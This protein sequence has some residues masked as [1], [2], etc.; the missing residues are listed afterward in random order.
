MT[1]RSGRFI[2]SGRVSTTDVILRSKWISFSEND[3][4]DD[5]QNT[6]GATCQRSDESGGVGVRAG[7]GRR[8]VREFLMI[9]CPSHA[10]R[11]GDLHIVER[12]IVFRRHSA[13]LRRDGRRLLAPVKRR[14]AVGGG[15]AGD[16]AAGHVFMKHSPRCHFRV[17]GAKKRVVDG[18]DVRERE[19]APRGV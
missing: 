11:D 17:D 9:L 4:K 2:A 5:D 10:E 18:R 13:N 12:E 6:D 7:V 16:D 14:E 8:A 15:G 19:V 3:N 1:I